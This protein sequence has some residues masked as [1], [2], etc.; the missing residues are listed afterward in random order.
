M[1]GQSLEDWSRQLAAGLSMQT[2]EPA[3]AS[4]CADKLVFD[5]QQAA[6]AAAIVAA[7]QHGSKLAAY[8]CR[9]CGF[10]HLKTDYLT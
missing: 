7:H 6:Q 1:D 8:R 3:E 4:P 9:Y 2:E 5:S 10:W